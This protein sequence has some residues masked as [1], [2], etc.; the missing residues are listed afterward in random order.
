MLRIRSGE[1]LLFIGDSITECG[2]ESVEPPLGGGFVQFVHCLLAARH[3]DVPV[4]IVNRGVAGDTIRDLERRWERD[5]IAERPDWLFV[6]IGVNDLLYR[7][8]EQPRHRAVG[9][10]EYA[11]TYRRLLARTR[12]A[13]S[14]RTALLEPTPLEEDLAA[15]SHAPMRNLCAIVREVAREHD[16]EVVPIFERFLATVGKAPARG[17]MI[18]VPH[19]NLKGQAILALAVLE[20]LGW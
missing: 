8:L 6:M 20:H 19:P 3:P 2:R 16:A 14:C 12:E 18:D 5:V 9:D 7:H 13:L 15:P 10:E 17:W 1:K 4:E 11:A